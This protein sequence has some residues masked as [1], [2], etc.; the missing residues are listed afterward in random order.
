MEQMEHSG[1]VALGNTN[2]ATRDI[3]SNI[4]SKKWVFTLN[5]Y[6]SDELEQLEQLFEGLEKWVIGEEVGEGGTPHLQGAIVSPLRI[7]PIEKFKNK[8]IH[9]E[10]M[11]GTDEQ[12][13]LYCMK[14]G[15]F[16]GKGL[17]KIKK[18]VKY[19]TPDRPYQKFILDIVSK[20]PDERAVYWFYEENG[21]VGK[22]S[23][24]KYLVGNLDA[25][26]IDEGKKTDIINVIYNTYI[27]N[28]DIEII[29]IDIPRSN[30]NNVSYKAIETIKNGM[31]CN[32][33][34]ETGN[35][36]FNSPHIIIFSNEMPDKSKLSEDRWHI[37]NITED[38][39]FVE[40]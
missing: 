20:E 34:Y 3:R 18:P 11:K 19:I 40:M 37:Y 15:N 24:C 27:A 33:K 26:Y 8:R 9:W 17:P 21:G 38:Y 14:D 1:A 36:I 32:T 30:G 5:N 16:K 10:K 2:K 23:F 31:I 13:F 7:R 35:A 39:N 29:V 25:I 12:A 28:K 22:S 4:M 6:T